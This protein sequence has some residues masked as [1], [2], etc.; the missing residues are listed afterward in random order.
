ME[1]HIVCCESKKEG[2]LP[3]T[4]NVRKFLEQKT[5]ELSCGGANRNLPSGERKITTEGISEHKQRP[6]D[7]EPNSNTVYTLPM[8]CSSIDTLATRR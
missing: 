4:E 8:I 7:V 2:H 6:R 3:Q 5:H 1:V